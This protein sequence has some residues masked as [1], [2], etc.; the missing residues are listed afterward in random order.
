VRNRFGGTCYRCGK[1]C[2]PRDGHFERFRRTWRVQH[3]SCAIKLRGTPDPEREAYRL[4]ELKRRATGT[5]KSAQRAR[6]ELRDRGL[7]A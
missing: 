5:G 1:W 7:T 3:A 2:A 6:R 4:E